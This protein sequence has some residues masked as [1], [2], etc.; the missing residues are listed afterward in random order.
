M[1]TIHDIKIKL[2]ISIFKE[3]KD[4]EY[5]AFS[6]ELQ[7]ATQGSTIAQVKKR[8]KERIEIFFEMAVERGDLIEKLKDLGWIGQERE[9]IK[10]PKSVSV[11][12]ELLAAQDCRKIHQQYS[13]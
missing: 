12:I 11:P 8:I 10:P 3:R 2:L 4:G 5:I 13:F 1:E 9:E 7:V 6:P